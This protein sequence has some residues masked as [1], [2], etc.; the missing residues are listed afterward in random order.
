MPKSKSLVE[1]IIVLLIDF[2]LGNLLYFYCSLC[3]LH[4]IHIHLKASKKT[5]YFF[6]YQH[7]MQEKSAC[8]WKRLIHDAEKV[9]E[10]DLKK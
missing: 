9:S 7:C 10:N 3:S 1:L 8:L 5:K 6:Y 4:I 2:K